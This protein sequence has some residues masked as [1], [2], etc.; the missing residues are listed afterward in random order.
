[1]KLSA[2]QRRALRRVLESES[3][4]VELD[5]L[6][7]EDVE[8]RGKKLGGLV[9][10]LQALGSLQL[11][12]ADGRVFLEEG[13]GSHES[14]ESHEFAEYDGSG[15]GPL[16]R[17][18]GGAKR[19]AARFAVR[20]FLEEGIAARKILIDNGAQVAYWHR[21]FVE[22]L[23][24]DTTGA[25]GRLELFYLNPIAFAECLRARIPGQSVTSLGGKLLEARCA[26]VGDQAVAAIEGQ[27]FT[28][29]I[30]GSACATTTGDLGQV[31]REVIGQKDAMLR[32]TGHVLV[33]LSARKILRP[34]M[35]GY[36]PLLRQ[37]TAP[38]SSDSGTG[39]TID[40]ALEGPN[41]PRFTLVVGSDPSTLDELAPARE[42]RQYYDADERVRVYLV[43]EN[44][45]VID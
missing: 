27:T 9:K 39:S 10:A 43:N 33:L 23:A 4:S 28:T 45:D 30:M 38:S 37:D 29:T 2:L 22:A 25:Q 21:E 14:H 13:R 36:L 31:T 41:Q 34:P 17:S 18:D 7:A 26:I 42:L 12:V 20:L 32:C 44:G 35:I 8:N 24:R 40:R 19:G 1:M 6:V 3:L 11:T 5:A 16:L 15:I